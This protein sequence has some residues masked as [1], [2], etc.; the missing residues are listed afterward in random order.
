[1]IGLLMTATTSFCMMQRAGVPGMQPTAAAS[2]PTCA[3]EL[4]SVPEEAVRLSEPSEEE[5]TP[6]LSSRHRDLVMLAASEFE[7]P[8]RFLA[9]AKAAKTAKAIKSSRSRKMGLRAAQPALLRGA[10]AGA[11]VMQFNF[12]KKKEEPPAKKSKSGGF[13]FGGSG[14]FDD[15]VDT[16][17]RP[18][19]VPN[20]VEQS[21]EN[22]LATEGLVYY[23]A[24]IPILLFF[25]AY[26]NGIFSFGYSKG[27]F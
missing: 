3:P 2:S 27:N 21:E 23:A 11:P 4:W 6:E 25:F 20:F 10:R 22:D 14:F 24:F 12:G 5:S 7:L 18:E 26:S 17:T 13:K 8:P 16:V 15:E 1:M 19:Y 9:A